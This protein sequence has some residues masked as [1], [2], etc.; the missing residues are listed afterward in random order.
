MFKILWCDANNAF[1]RNVDFSHQEQRQRYHHGQGQQRKSLPLLTPNQTA[2]GHGEDNEHQPRR[3]GEFALTGSGG[4][5][6]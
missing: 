3:I 2:G 4:L 6:L 5:L 1:T